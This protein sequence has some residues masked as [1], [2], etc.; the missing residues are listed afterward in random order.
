MTIPP[1]DPG[2]ERVRRPRRFVTAAII[3]AVLLAIVLGIGLFKSMNDS[4]MLCPPS[5]PD[6]GPL[7]P[8]PPPA[9]VPLPR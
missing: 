8:S 1:P 3:I 7:P 5:N 9:P 2:E 4:R 6:C